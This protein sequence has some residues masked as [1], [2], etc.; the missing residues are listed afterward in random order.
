MK[1]SLFLFLLVLCGC[2][3]E[4]SL[5]WVTPGAG[6]QVSGVVELKVEAIGET[7]PSNVVFA[8]DNTPVAKVYAEENQFS[9]VWNSKNVPPGSVT[10]I[11]KPYGGPAISRVINVTNAE[12][13]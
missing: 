11:A 1:R 10:L 7:P 8:V 9:A 6:H 4:Q 13:E 2:T 3:N 5:V 12:G